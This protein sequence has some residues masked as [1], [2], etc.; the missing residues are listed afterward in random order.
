MVKTG[1]RIGEQWVIT[2]GLKPG[3]KVVLLGNK[4]IR[5]NTIVKPIMV[6]KDSTLNK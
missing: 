3:D 1:P 2:E 4:M 6:V 5:P